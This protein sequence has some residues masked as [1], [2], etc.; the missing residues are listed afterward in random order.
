MTVNNKNERE[1]ANEENYTHYQKQD[2]TVTLEQKLLNIK[3]LI[4]EKDI[5]N[6]SEKYGP[7]P[8]VPI[9]VK[10][11]RK[12]LL[13]HRHVHIIMPILA[14]PNFISFLRT[15]LSLLNIH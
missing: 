1:K 10:L 12:T 4:L 5:D 15:F 14:I 9:L 3:F 11:S 13:G 6:M 8:S 7:K 2:H